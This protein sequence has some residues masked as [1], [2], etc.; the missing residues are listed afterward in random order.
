ME[1]LSN[2][3]VRWLVLLAR[4]ARQ[5]NTETIYSS[6]LGCCAMLCFGKMSTFRGTYSLHFQSWSDESKKVDG[7][8]RVRRSIRPGGLVNQS[9]KKW[10]WNHIMK[11]FFQGTRQE[12]WSGERKRK[13]S[14]FKG[15]KGRSH[16]EEVLFLE[17]IFFHCFHDLLMENPSFLFKLFGW[18]LK[19]KN[20]TST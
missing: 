7:L 17:R 13:S 15:Q 10:R 4:T 16:Q 2:E 12:G 20:P 6:L 8:W 18:G 14:P 5:T 11:Q 3:K 19:T 1:L 9:R